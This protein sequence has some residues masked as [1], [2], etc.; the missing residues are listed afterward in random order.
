MILL[1]ME[2]RFLAQHLRT[3]RPFEALSFQPEN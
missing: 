3:F 1:S 2:V